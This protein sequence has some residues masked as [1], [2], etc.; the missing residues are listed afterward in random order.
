VQTRMQASIA[1]P[2]PFIT[3]KFLYC[4]VISEI[5][6][7]M[8]SISLLYTEVQVLV[9]WLHWHFKTWYY[10]R[11]V[12][13][14]FC[15]LLDLRTIYSIK[16]LQIWYLNKENVIHMHNATSFTCNEDWNHDFWG[17]VDGMY[18]EILCL[19]IHL[20]SGR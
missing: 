9:K 15:F 1:S 14:T 11:K 13:I 4:K 7:E 19:V 16:N 20:D 8:L 5:F 3:S 10:C 12:H 17:K 18:L 2:T 6:K